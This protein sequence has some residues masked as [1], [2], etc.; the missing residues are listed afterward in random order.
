MLAEWCAI[1]QPAPTL[2]VYN[3]ELPQPAIYCILGC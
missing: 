1:F 3:P 2:T